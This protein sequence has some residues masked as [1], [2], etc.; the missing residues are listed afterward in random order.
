[1]S[2]KEK[3]TLPKWFDGEVYETGSEV[4]NSLSGYSC[5]LNA[6]E[7]SMYDVIKGAE[8]AMTMGFTDMNL[9]NKIIKR[10]VDWFIANNPSAYYILLN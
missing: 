2:N 8:I 3:Q 10:G 6:K 5:L 9:C 1:M 7:L 4:V